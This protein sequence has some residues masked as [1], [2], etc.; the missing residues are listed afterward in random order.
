M[1][2]ARI[3]L[4]QW[5]ALVSVVESGGYAKAGEALHKSQSTLTYS[6]QKIEELLGVKVFEIRGRKAVLTPVGEVLYRRGKTLIDEAVRLEHAA[7]QLAKGWEPE[8][9]LAV[10]IVF[11]TWLLVQCLGAFSAERP[12][13]RIE[14]YETVLGGTDEALAA[15]S[16]DFAIASSVPPG[17]MGDVLM[18]VRTICVAAP[19]H[20]LHHLGRP[21][22]LDD[23]RHHRHLVIR[24][25]GVRRTRSAGFLNEE[26]W[27]VSHKATSLHALI[28][29][30]GY[31]WFPEEAI[32]GEL[33]RGALVPVPLREGAERQGPLYLVFTDRDAAGP[34]TL[35][36]ADLIRTKVKE[37]CSRELSRT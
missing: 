34:G 7:G 27:T 10:E 11:P 23:L 12:D 36:L 8:I 31:A 21:A 3:S 19:S 13:T 24:D 33:E 32:R 15:R 18:Q 17:F 5:A 20:P 28:L 9:R 30:Y 25:S 1:P 14:L 2:A 16:V 37:E 6:I 35:R 22:T 4:D 29:G 26:R